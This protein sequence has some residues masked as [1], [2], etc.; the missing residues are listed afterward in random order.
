MLECLN[1]VR[2]ATP[3]GSASARDSATGCPCWRAVRRPQRTCRRYRSLLHHWRSTVTMGPPDVSKQHDSR[4][5]CG[6]GQYR[7]TRRA[8]SA[9]GRRN[10]RTAPIPRTL[11]RPGPVGGHRLARLR[12]G[13]P[14]GCGRGPARGRGNAGARHRLSCAGTARGADAARRHSHLGGSTL[15]IRGCD[16]ERAS[17]HRAPVR[18]HAG[19]PDGASGR[20]A[21]AQRG[22]SPHRGH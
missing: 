12:D 11:P 9:L 6:H 22:Q 20:P 18:D 15:R 1:Q 17:A 19:K 14:T 7:A 2:P 13:G 16:V 4:P 5:H 8:V 21:S 3:P 10:R